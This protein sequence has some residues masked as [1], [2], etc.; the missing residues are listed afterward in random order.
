MPSSKERAECIVKERKV[1]ERIQKTLKD[2][3]ENNVIYFFEVSKAN[4]NLILE[5]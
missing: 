1:K 3:A 4:W 2:Q 5:K